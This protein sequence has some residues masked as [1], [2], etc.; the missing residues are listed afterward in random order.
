[1]KRGVLLTAA[2]LL[3]VVAAGYDTY[4][5]WREREAFELWEMNPIVRWTAKAGGLQ[6]VFLFKAA[7]LA[8][9]IGLAIYCHFTNPRLA[10]RFTTVVGSTY[11]SLSLYYAYCQIEFP[12]AKAA[13]TPL[14]RLSPITYPLGTQSPARTAPRPMR[15]VRI[16]EPRA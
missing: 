13:Q 3:I 8:F 10:R 1:M 12:R 11:L 4:F 9:G 7:G 14:A 16:S 6:V 15:V 2:W 5:A